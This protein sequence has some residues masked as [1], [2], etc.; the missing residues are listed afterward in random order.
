MAAWRRKLIALFPELR[1]EAEATDFAPYDA[2]VELL[3][4]CR[5]AHELNDHEALVSVYAFAEWCSNQDAKELWNS[6]GVSFYEHL[7]DTPRVMW[8]DIIPWL[9][10]QI[11]AACR[12]LWEFRLTTEDFQKVSDLIRNCKSPRHQD[13]QDRINSV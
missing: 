6:A 12:G 8:P 5:R 11:V 1:Q 10:P 2:L 9:S 4:K 13:L 3:P 7:F